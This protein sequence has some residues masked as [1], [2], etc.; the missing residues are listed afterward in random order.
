MESKAQEITLQRVWEPCSSFLQILTFDLLTFDCFRPLLS[1]SRHFTNFPF[2]NLF[3]RIAFC[4]IWTK[5]FY[6]GLV[7][8][9]RLF[10]FVCVRAG[11]I[12]WY[13]FSFYDFCCCYVL[14]RVE[15]SRANFKGLEIIKSARPPYKIYLLF[16]RSFLSQI[17]VI[18]NK[19]FAVILGWQ[20]NSL[21]SFVCCPFVDHVM[22]PLK[23]LS[24]K[25]KQI[26]MGMK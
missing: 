11:L 8:K 6:L 12:F 23:I 9:E 19:Q 14:P 7:K 21:A 13:Q 5:E 16:S 24:F 18:Q 22:L 26:R 3:Q 20:Q 15:N 25:F 4:G 10:S 1:G 2:P 17:T